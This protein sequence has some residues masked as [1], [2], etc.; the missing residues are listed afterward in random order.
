MLGW[1]R[2]QKPP[3]NRAFSTVRGDAGRFARILTVLD[4]LAPGDL[5]VIEPLLPPWVRRERRLMQRDAAVQD[6]VAGH[7]LDCG[8]G[9][10]RG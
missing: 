8:S 1:T 5:E 9:R 6:L 4:R 3:K 7:Y 10:G 2:V